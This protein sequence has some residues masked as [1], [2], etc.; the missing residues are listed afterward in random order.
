[1]NLYG[2]VFG[3]SRI[4]TFAEGKKIL[5]KASKEEQFLS[6]TGLCTKRISTDGS[7]LFLTDP[8]E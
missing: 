7:Y 4:F 1:M 2:V 3:V 6:V 5:W 8:T